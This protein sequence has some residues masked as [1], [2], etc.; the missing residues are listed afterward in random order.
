ML[1]WVRRL[2]FVSLF[3]E[4]LIQSCILNM[5]VSNLKIFVINLQIYITYITV[6]MQ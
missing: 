5:I 6:I 2:T 1:S 4:N 3:L